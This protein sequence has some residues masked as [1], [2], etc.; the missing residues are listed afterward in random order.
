MMLPKEAKDALKSLENINENLLK[1]RKS[2]GDL[3]IAI[4]EHDDSIKELKNVINENAYDVEKRLDM[5]AQV[6]VLADSG[7]SSESISDLMGIPESSV[8]AFKKEN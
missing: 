7:Y 2:L 6:K 4:K 8:R 1:I 3:N 5:I